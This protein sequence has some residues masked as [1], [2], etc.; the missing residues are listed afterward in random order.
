MYAMHI[1]FDDSYFSRS[2]DMISG[3][4]IE[5]GSCDPDHAPFRSDWSSKS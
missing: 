1:K 2:G 5:N 4:K 3:I